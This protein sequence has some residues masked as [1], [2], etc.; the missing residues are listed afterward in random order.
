MYLEGRKLSWCPPG[1]CCGKGRDA[2]GEKQRLRKG[3]KYNTRGLRS[4]L[5][6]HIQRNSPKSE[7]PNPISIQSKIQS[8]L[9]TDHKKDPDSEIS[10]ESKSGHKI[11]KGKA[12]NQ[13]VPGFI[14]NSH[15]WANGCGTIPNQETG[16]VGKIT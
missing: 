14:M 2:T 10:R 16:V 11:N 7:S 4:S 9:K 12:K 8:G 3:N 6:A 5:Y 1:T 15:P 13:G